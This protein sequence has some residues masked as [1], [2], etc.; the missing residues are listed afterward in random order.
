M[1]ANAPASSSGLSATAWPPKLAAAPS[2]GV[3]VPVMPVGFE[4]SVR[5]KAPSQYWWKSSAS[6]RQSLKKSSVTTQS[7]SGAP[8]RP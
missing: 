6:S 1:R 2:S 8:S 5:A 3:P 4:N 7:S